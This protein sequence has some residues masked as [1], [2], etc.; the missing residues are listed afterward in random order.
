MNYSFHRFVLYIIYYL[1]FSTKLKKNRIGRRKRNFKKRRIKQWNYQ[2]SYRF[3]SFFFPFRRHSSGLRG[4]RRFIPTRRLWETFIFRT[5][6]SFSV[7][8][9]VSHNKLDLL[10]ARMSTPSSSSPLIHRYKCTVIFIERS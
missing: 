2:N 5:F 8:Q 7:Y 4:F 9:S 3:F 10:I 6:R 1:S